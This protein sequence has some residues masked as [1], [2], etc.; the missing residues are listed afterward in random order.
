M[1]V[2]CA[3]VLIA[4]LAGCTQARYR[5]N[6]CDS[7]FY[8]EYQ[9]LVEPKVM[10][11]AIPAADPQTAT[12]YKTRCW[13]RAAAVTPPPD[14]GSQEAMSIVIAG[15]L[16]DCNEH[17][18]ANNSGRKAQALDCRIAA[19]N[20]VWE[21]WVT[22]LRAADA[23]A[24][25][26]SGESVGVAASA[27]TVV[28]SANPMD[29]AGTNVRPE[30]ALPN[31]ASPPVSSVSTPASSSWEQIGSSGGQ[32]KQFGF[33]NAFNWCPGPGDRCNN[34]RIIGIRHPR[35]GQLIGRLAIYMRPQEASGN[36]LNYTFQLNNESYCKLEMETFEITQD[37]QV[38]GA[39]TMADPYLE[40]ASTRTVSETVTFLDG[41]SSNAVVSVS[42]LARECPL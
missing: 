15:V 3:M 27:T 12:H 28:N 31:F 39:W 17:K 36:R 22:E 7:F 25:G 30:S 37:G 13:A 34:D 10:A 38:L 20:S 4:V 29:T 19:R 24:R 1:K 5:S 14:M 32:V 26:Y 21:P 33:N 41:A 8:G 18:N 11:V 6:Q 35:T 9:T 40:P 2:I 42:G 23:R 16:R